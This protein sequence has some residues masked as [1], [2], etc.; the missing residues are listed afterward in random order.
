MTREG[1]QSLTSHQYIVGGEV[2]KVGTHGSSRSSD[3]TQGPKPIQF[4]QVKDKHC[5]TM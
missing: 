1:Q 3:M 4:G 2:E 5:E